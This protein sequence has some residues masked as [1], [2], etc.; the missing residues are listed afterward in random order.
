MTYGSDRA[1]FRLWWRTRDGSDGSRDY[2]GRFA[3]EAAYVAL[4]SGGQAVRAAFF[5]DGEPEPRKTFEV[6]GTEP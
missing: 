4:C 3:A 1:A 5:E 2:H 6:C